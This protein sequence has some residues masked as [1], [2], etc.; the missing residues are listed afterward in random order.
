[1]FTTE[2]EYQSNTNQDA[3]SNIKDGT[4]NSYKKFLNK[5]E[6]AIFRMN[7]MS[8]KNNNDSHSL[9]DFQLQ[10]HGLW[11]NIFLIFIN[12]FLLLNCRMNL[13]KN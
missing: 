8:S 2:N 6:F 12:T 13:L 1:M 9:E 3:L 10:K 4:E 11:L 5:I 7:Q